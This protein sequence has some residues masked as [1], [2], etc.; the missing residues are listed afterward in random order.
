MFLFGLPVNE[1][2]PGARENGQRSE[3]SKKAWFF[4]SLVGLVTISLFFVWFLLFS[5]KLMEENP[6]V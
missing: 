2:K 1:L 6:D 3:S 5:L 4:F